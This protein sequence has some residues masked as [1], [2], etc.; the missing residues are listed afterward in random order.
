MYRIQITDN[1]SKNAETC[2]EK[3]WKCEE[4]CEIIPAVQ[5]SVINVRS[6]EKGR[7][8]VDCEYGRVTLLYYLTEDAGGFGIRIEA[9]EIFESK[10]VAGISPIRE[11]VEA[12]IRDFCAGAVFP[13]SLYDVVYDRLAE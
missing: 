11:E 2:D 8:R 3:S 5:G 13:I 9:R 12:M 1:L 7:T 6:Y 4:N 10:T